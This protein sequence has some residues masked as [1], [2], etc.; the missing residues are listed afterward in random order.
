[1]FTRAST[2]TDAVEAARRR[3]AL[4][5]QQFERGADPDPASHA[6]TAA[7]PV[8]RVAAEAVDAR[9][10]GR[11]AASGPRP[12]PRLTPHHLA[13]A[14]LAVAVAVVVA[15]WWVLR[16]AGGSEPLPVVPRQVT[17]PASAPPAGDPEPGAMDAAAAPTGPASGEPTSGA[18]TVVID[19]VGKVRRP[20]IL[21][22]PA[23]SRVADALEAAGGARR[24]V[25]VST[26]NLARPLV[27]GEQV[28]VGVDPPAIVP[29]PVAPPA[30]TSAPATAPVNL[31]TAT[32]EQL[33]ALPGV[34]PVTALAI[35]ELRGQNGSFGAVDDLLAVSGIGPATLEDLRPYVFV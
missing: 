28:V 15:G 30:A 33:E 2:S 22:L 13:L 35:L 23:G 19:V 17:A 7:E 6:T 25:D 1:M 34:G 14:A 29:S 4:L 18:P 3:L 8:D 16:A 20:G 27:D 12:R 5:S 24:G 21:E 26:L 10:G 11:H 32:Q 31:N 9:P